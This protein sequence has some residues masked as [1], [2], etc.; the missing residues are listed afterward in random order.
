MHI[1]SKKRLQFEMPYLEDC[2]TSENPVRAIDAFVDV[3]DLEK[4]GFVSV[5]LEFISGESPIPSAPFVNKG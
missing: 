2:I 5:I 3:I 4:L 1:T